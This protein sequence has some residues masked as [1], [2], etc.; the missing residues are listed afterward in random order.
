[1]AT[2]KI[3]DNA[4]ELTNL[5]GFEAQVAS[6]KVRKEEPSVKDVKEEPVSSTGEDTQLESEPSTKEEYEARIKGLQA[7]LS[8]RK[9]NADKVEEL[10]NELTYMK[11][12]LD[13]LAA[14]KTTTSAED[15]FLEAVQKLDDEALV[16]KQGDWEEEIASLRGKFDRAEELGDVEKMNS[17]AQKIAN[18]KWV[19]TKLRTE[20]L[21]RSE[22]RVNERTNQQTEFESLQSELGEMYD[23]VREQ[24]PDFTNEESELWKAGK[25]EFDSHPVLMSKLGV[26]GQVV[27]AAM[28]IVKNPDLAGGKETGEVRKEL[29]ETIDKGLTKAL[30]TGGSAPRM[31]QQTSFD[32]ESGD[33]LA[34]FNKLVDRYKGG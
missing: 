15:K 21:N 11:G 22:R 28:A 31:Q 24:F 34:A 23:T 4:P 16:S 26:A 25:A 10:T 1:M 18:A 3:I 32:V 30:R 7:E 8:R 13:T 27:A 14:A 19:I 33:G 12:Q 29:I 17:I 5:E 6:A 9:G 2:E 20:T